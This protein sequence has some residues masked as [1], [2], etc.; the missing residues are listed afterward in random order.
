MDRWNKE[1]QVVV[2]GYD[3]SQAGRVRMVRSLLYQVVDAC[4]TNRRRKEPPDETE[5]GDY[6]PSIRRPR[7]G[8]EQLLVF[9]YTLEPLNPIAPGGE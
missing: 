8:T 1:S 9:D 4:G 2:T 5:Q 3:R 7:P 6:D